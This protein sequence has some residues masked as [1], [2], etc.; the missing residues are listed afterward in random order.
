MMK[1]ILPLMAAVLF[2]V[3][4]TAQ[5]QTTTLNLNATPQAPQA[6]FQFSAATPYCNGTR[7]A[8][9]DGNGATG[10]FAFLWPNLFF[11]YPAG[12]MVYDGLNQGLGKIEQTSVSVAETWQGATGSGTATYPFRDPNGTYTGTLQWTFNLVR[13]CGRGCYTYGYI[14]GGR[15]TMTY[16]H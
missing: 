14:T 3:C 13:R 7:F 10:S 6:C 12:N 4:A 1:S 2:A 9:T 11:D 5:A 8:F 15:I 16:A